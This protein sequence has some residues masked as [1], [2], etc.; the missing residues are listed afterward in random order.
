MKGFGI[1]DLNVLLLSQDGFLRCNNCQKYYYDIIDNDSNEC[2]TGY[3]DI[4]DDYYSVCPKCGN[5]EFLTE[6]SFNEVKSDIRNSKINDI[7]L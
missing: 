5:D 2:L 3:K 6:V 4:N 1:K 7:L